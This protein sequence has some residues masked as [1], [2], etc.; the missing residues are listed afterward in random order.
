MPGWFSQQGA[1][2]VARLRRELETLLDRFDR[3]L[4]SLEADVVGFLAHRQLRWINAAIEGGVR[5]DVAD[6][7][8]VISSFLARVAAGDYGRRRNVYIPAGD[9]RISTAV[10]HPA[11]VRV[12]GDGPWTR[13]VQPNGA[14]NTVWTFATG[15]TRTELAHC[16][17]IGQ[18]DDPA[19]LTDRRGVGIDCSESQRVKLHSLQVW[20]FFVGIL[21][22]DGTPFSAYHSWG[23]DIE[24]N[25]CTT[26]VRCLDEFN[27]SRFFDSRVFYSYGQ[28]SNGIGVDV[29][30]VGGMRIENVAIEACDTCLRVRCTNGLLELTCKSNY[31]EPG[32]N[33]TTAVVGRAYDVFFENQ[34]DGTEIFEDTGS[35]VSALNGDVVVPPDAF[36]RTDGYSRAFY[37]ARFDGAAV[38]KR[39][40]VR[41][42]SL[43]Q[44]ALPDTLPNWFNGGSSP[45]VAENTSDFVTGVRSMDV[46]AVATGST[47]FATFTVSDPG[48]DWVTCGVRYRV[49]SG[50]VGFF[51]AG[52]VGSN[53]RQLSDEEDA[54]EWRV[55]WVQVP[56]D[57]SNRTGSITIVPDSV[58][59]SGSVRIDAVWAVAGRYAIPQTQYGERVLLLPS[60]IPFLSGSTS[61]NVSFGPV[62][63]TNLPAVLAPPLDTFGAA[64]LGVVGAILRVRVEA[65]DT[66]GGL[67]PLTSRVY[68]YVDIPAT[69]ASTIAADVQRATPVFNTI[70]AE[71]TI[72]VRDTTISG[73]VITGIS[74]DY[75]LDLI[76]WI[77]E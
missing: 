65:D 60:P 37:G 16:Q 77:L 41:N 56:V 47:F 66:S 54:D 35:V 73:G 46:T 59:G 19:D 1:G 45:T 9:Y 32:T 67:A 63:I 39:N 57:P 18:P 55:R 7:G 53:T 30:D 6:A 23:P 17:I 64:P 51:F 22:S 21:G 5:P 27:V 10:V 49:A 14:S 28:T 3:R 40:L 70:P 76:G 58:G 43:N 29:D 68:C 8:P 15:F 75:E 74:T 44:W 25:R 31:Y 4:K 2:P 52:S 20:D 69:G 61:G 11:G 26:G 12:W 33:P 38:P 42:G 72:I 71:A 48:V 24:V 36:V 62:D 50:N 13:F 34:F